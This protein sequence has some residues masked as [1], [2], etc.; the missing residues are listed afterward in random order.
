GI[1]AA[2]RTRRRLG[3]GGEG[4]AGHDGHPDRILGSVHAVVPPSEKASPVGLPDCNGGVLPAGPA[5]PPPPGGGGGRPRPGRPG[6]AG[7]GGGGGGG[8]AGGGG[9]GG[10]RG[11]GGGA[12]GG[13]GGWRGGGGGGGP[14]RAP[15]CPSE[16]WQVAQCP[17]KIVRPGSG[18]GGLGGSGARRS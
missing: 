1:P 5:P 2:G 3:G 4:P 9:G 16:P 17:W 6:G 10:G 12:A 13:G 11:G 18:P 14:R 7:G 8:G 15:P